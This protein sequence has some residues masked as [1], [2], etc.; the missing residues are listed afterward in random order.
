MTDGSPPDRDP[1]PGRRERKKLATRHA[2]SAA[3]LQLATER[4]LENVTIED[5]TARADVALRTFR[6][7]F[8]SKYEAI[9]AIAADRARQIGATLLDRPASEPLREALI[10]AV[11]QHYQGTD[12][13]L[14]HESM[15]AIKLVAGSPAIRGEYLKINAEMQDALAAAIGERTGT[16][17][18]TDMYPQIL[19]GAVIAAT[20]VAIRRWFRADPPEPLLPIIELALRQLA[21]VCSE[22]AFSDQQRSSSSCV[23]QLR[24]SS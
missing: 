13:A 3:A 4:G 1:L 2:L 10:N 16:D 14:G 19:A 6:N 12:L 8:A 24:L 22:P 18:G 21:G 5:I 23:P 15:A 17:P 9:C 20:Q 11:L 7:Y